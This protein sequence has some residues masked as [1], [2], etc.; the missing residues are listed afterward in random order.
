MAQSLSRVKKRIDTVQSTKKITNSMKLVSSVKLKQLSR[1]LEM[2]SFYFRA[3]KRVYE[4]A[5]FENKYN[6]EKFDLIFFDKYT[7]TNKKIHI[8][9]SS[10]MG[11]C[12]GYNNNIFKFAKDYINKGDEVIVIGEKSLLHYSKYKDIKLNTNYLNITNNINIEKIH[13]LTNYLIK[14]YK[15]KQYSG[16]DIIYTNYIN[17][18]NFNP[19]LS[20][21]LPL[22]ISVN[23]RAI[24]SPIYEPNKEAV[25]DYLIIEYLSTEIY[26]NILISLISEQSSRR[27]TMDNADKNAQNLIDELKLEYNKARQSSITQELTEIINGSLAVK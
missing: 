15:T 14:Q 21:L 20:E 6:D 12:G 4:D 26:S 19:T 16:I 13:I 27:N 2:Q 18:I 11:L 7:N 10:N 17:S 22:K 8:I 1:A 25:L 5:V 3:M 24:H 9:I 23:E